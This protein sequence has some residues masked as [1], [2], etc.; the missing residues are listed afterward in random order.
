M[1]HLLQSS[2]QQA[3]Q[4]VDEL[5]IML[6]HQAGRSTERNQQ[7]LRRLESQLRMLNPLA[8]LDRGY[9]LTL[10]PDGT[11]VRSAE[12]VEVGEAITTRLADGKVVSNVMEKE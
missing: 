3:H 4:R 7:K 5:C 2:V 8:V 1:V 12:A 10:K 6:Q 11:V 9:S